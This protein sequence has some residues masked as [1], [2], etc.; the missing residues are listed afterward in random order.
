MANN[1]WAAEVARIQAAIKQQ[2]A[3]IAKFE[4]QLAA[5]PGSIG[6]QQSIDSARSYLADL[7]QQLNIVLIEY[8][9]FASQPVASSGDV[10]G[11][12]NQARDNNANA[13]RPPVGQ[14]IITPVG[15]IEP[16]GSG[17]GTNAQ[18]TP[19]TET[20]PTVG[21]NAETRP[22]SQTQAINNRSNQAIPNPVNGLD[23][24]PDYVFPASA[25]V[26][27]TGSGARSDDNTP[28]TPSVVVNRLDA[29]YA[30]KNN[31]IHEQPNVLDN[32]FNYTYS[33][34]W[35][36]ATPVSYNTTIGSIKQNLNGYY[37]LAQSG[38]AGISPGTSQSQPTVDVYVP[39][40]D[41][42]YQDKP[43]STIVGAE[44]NRYFNL[45]Y[46]IDNLSIE[47]AYSAGINSGGPIAI[48]NI[49]F[50]ISEP[51]GI[52]LP[53]NLYR[54]VNE[55]YNQT[56]T[57]D[58]PGN[59]V[60][61]ASAMYCMVIRF[62]GYNEKGQLVQ[63]ITNNVGST[64]PNAAVEKFIFY[65]QTSLNYSVGSKLTEYRITGASPSTNIGFSVNRGSIPF[66][67]QFTG[68]TVKDVLVGQIKQQ[69]ASQAAGDKTRNNI[70][71][72][73]TAPGAGVDPNTIN[74]QGAAF[75]GGGL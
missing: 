20:N 4:G 47:T 6:I 25:P 18:P 17:S 70:P 10:V 30:A 43:G 64:D 53:L 1:P 24:P 54:A 46:Y 28:A 48:K 12:A 13:T 11:N 31:Y 15:R 62:Y 57:K 3:I 44:R 59:F 35:Y 67:M 27:T 74:P 38:G 61:Y 41:K 68:T 37:L 51:N 72:S 26:G 55:V 65:Q 32:Y 66:N 45:D 9:N 49:S 21:T 63:P 33:L 29:L 50:T 71:I 69:T 58:S 34:S 60:N 19:T 39:G 52:T 8:N 2:Q 56:T 75:G 5:A 7:Q 22:I 42:K 23:L 36:L 73:P 14:E 40:Y 16:G